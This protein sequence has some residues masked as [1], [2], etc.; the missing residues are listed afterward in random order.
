M[1]RLKKK[2]KDTKLFR[3]LTLVC[4]KLVNLNHLRLQSVPFSHFSSVFE[5]GHATCLNHVLNHV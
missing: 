2:C 5:C 3:Y 4:G 1:N